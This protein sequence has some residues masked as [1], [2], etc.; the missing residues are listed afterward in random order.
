MVG[1]EYG[2]TINYAGQAAVPDRVGRTTYFLNARGIEG[3]VPDLSCPEVDALAGD[4]LAAGGDEAGRTSWLAAVRQCHD[5]W[6]APGSTWRRTARTAWPAD[7]LALVR[8]LGVDSWGMG[9]WGGASVVALRVLAEDPPGLDA[10]FMDSPQLPGDD[11]RLPWRATRGGASARCWLT[12]ARTPSVAAAAHAGGPGPGSPP[13]SGA[14]APHGGRRDGPVTCR[15]RHGLLRLVRHS[16]AH[17][18][19]GH[20]R[21]DHGRRAGDDRRIPALDPADGRRA[22]RRP[23]RQRAVLRGVPGPAPPSTV[24]ASAWCSP[25]SAATTTPRP[26]RFRATTRRPVRRRQPVRDGVRRWD[27]RA[28]DTPPCRRPPRTCRP[29]CASASTTRSPTRTGSGRRS[30]GCRTPT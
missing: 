6:W 4:L 24:P 3:S 5:R 9:T 30:P 7:V 18:G 17:H 25:S 16:L 19:A 11:P 10:V 13:S 1:E 22:P 12:V 8:A 20:A 23:P 29:W 26:R 28:N 15:R 2:S 14:A 21:P 27:C